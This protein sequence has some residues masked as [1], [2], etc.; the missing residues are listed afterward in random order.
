MIK[1]TRNIQ[2]NKKCD[3]KRIYNRFKG[4]QSPSPSGRLLN[5]LT[6]EQEPSSI[7]HHSVSLNT[8]GY[9]VKLYTV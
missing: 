9:N 8:E 1:L 7:S 6:G 2:L 5:C 4:L 3:S